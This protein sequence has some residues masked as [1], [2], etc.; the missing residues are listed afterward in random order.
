MALSAISLAMAAEAVAPALGAGVILRPDAPAGLRIEWSQTIASPGDDWINDIFPEGTAQFGLAGFVNRGDGADADWRALYGRLS[1]DG[2]LLARHEYGAGHG[3]DAFWTG[4]VG[5]AGETWLGGFTSRIGAGGIDAWV[6]RVAANGTLIE[7]KTFGGG[8][9]DRFTGMA[10]AVDGHVFVGHSEPKGVARRRLLAVKLDH[11]G[12]VVW[13]R[14]IDADPN[15]LA[16]LYVEP[17]GDG[18]FI[19]AGGLGHG[20]DSDI[21]VLKLDAQGQELW[22]RTVGTPEAA[23]VNHGLLVRPD[24]TIVVVGYVKSWGSRDN[25]ILAAS[26]SPDGVLVKKALLGGAGDDRPILLK[27]GPGGGAWVVGYTKSART[28]GDWDMIVARLDSTGEFMPGVATIGTAADDNGTA[29]RPLA[30][31]G[32]IVAGYSRGLGTAS[33]DAFVVRLSPADWSWVNPAFE[34]RIVP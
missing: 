12:L 24:G 9:Y 14:I 19:V 28:T 16:A 10:A 22:R 11:K 29:I 20:E 27:A 13:Q 8:G 17:A 30:D 32:A 21:F 6:A 33:E 25:D 26:F 23:D 18:G 5:A 15:A 3:I 34:R 4:A 31:G 7:E 2:K 1:A